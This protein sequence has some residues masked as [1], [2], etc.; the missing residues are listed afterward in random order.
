MDIIV[1]GETHSFKDQSS[2]VEMLQQLEVLSPKGIAIAV[3]DS[4][5]PKVEWASRTLVSKD[6][7]TIIRATQGG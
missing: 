5:V 1:N 6:Q 4:V 3:N 7:I 2:I